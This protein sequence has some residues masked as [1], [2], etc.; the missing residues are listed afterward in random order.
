MVSVRNSESIAVLL[1]CSRLQVEIDFIGKF[2]D[3]PSNGLSLA[4]NDAEEVYTVLER[5]R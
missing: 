4:Q 1:T 3:S 2:V 5:K